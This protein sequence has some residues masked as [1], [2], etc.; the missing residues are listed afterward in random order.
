MVWGL[1]NERPALRDPAVVLDAIVELTEPRGVS[2]ARYRAGALDRCAAPDATLERCLR[3]G[4]ASP[5]RTMPGRH[6]CTIATGSVPP[7]CPRSTDDGGAVCAHR[8]IGWKQG[9]VALPE[10]RARERHLPRH[11]LAAVET[12]LVTAAATATEHGATARAMISGEWAEVDASPDRARFLDRRRGQRMSV[13]ADEVTSAWRREAQW[14]LARELSGKARVTRPV[15][16]ERVR[17]RASS[18]P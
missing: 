5:Y 17:E 18:R 11:I 2:S 7:Y 4:F 1:V 3:L 10:P 16:S 8:R 9:V 14:R 13:P 6:Y 12:A 15:H